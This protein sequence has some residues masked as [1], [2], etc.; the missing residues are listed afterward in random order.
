VPVLLGEQWIEIVP[1]LP[2]LSAAM[3]MLTL[4]ILFAPAVNARGF[5][6]IPLRVTILGSVA[7]PLAFLAGSQMGLAGF[8]WGWVGGMAVLLVATILLSQRA[9]GFSLTGLARAIL[10]P[11]IAALV[12]A[13]GVALMLRALPQAVLPLAALA[14]AVVLGV[15]LYLGALRLI[16][17]DRLTEALHF[18]RNR[19][20][21]DDAPGPLPAE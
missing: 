1:L 7:M 19:G 3:A 8:A 4:Q 16:A 2:I 18:A 20:A 13:G 17:P 14:G 9:L 10:P 21:G 15:A 6:G 11:L 5:P 12:M